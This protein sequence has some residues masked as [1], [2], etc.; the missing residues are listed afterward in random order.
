LSSER[1]R[2]V[3]RGFS[4]W[5]KPLPSQDIESFFVSV[6]S[7]TAREEELRMLGF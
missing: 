2:T 4:L 1:R 3:Q 7:A 6:A 5:K